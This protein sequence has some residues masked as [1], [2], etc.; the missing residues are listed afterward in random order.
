MRV[1]LKPLA[2]QT[3]VITGGSSG[4]GLATAREAVRRGAAV[5]L[6]ARNGEALETIA[7]EL[8]SEGRRVATCAI[9]VTSEGAAERIAAAALDAFGG[10]DSWVHAAAVTSY[11]SLEQ[12]GLEEHR[13]VFD[14]DYFAML[15]ANL[16]AVDHLRTQ[17]GGAI[18]NIGSVLSD[19]A[20]IKQP[21]YCAAKAA[22]RS[23]TDSLR[24]DVEREGLPISVTLIKP[25]GIHTPFPE[26]GRNHMDEPPRIPQIMYDPD[27]V[28]DAILYAAEHPRRQIYVGGAGITQSLLAQLFPR[29]TDRIMELTMV[30]AQQSTDEPGDP[31]MRDNLFQPRKDGLEEGTQNFAVKRWSLSLQAQKH[32]LAAT[33]I[34]AAGVLAI[35]AA[36]RSRGAPLVP[37]R[38]ED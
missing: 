30:R 34:A 6:A 4:I 23:L 5:V 37:E 12:L 38:V 13:R 24:M 9:D 33:A 14:V 15:Q 29:L 20:A 26:H 31:A 16:V 17:G 22:V 18:I 27:L 19:R 1:R 28:A 11:G 35:G 8:R 32:P 10:F 2:E 21:A 25:A 36:L 3:I 7:Q